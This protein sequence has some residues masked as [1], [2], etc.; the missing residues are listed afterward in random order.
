MPVMDGYQA[1]A[2]IRALEKEG[3]RHLPIVAMTANAM[4]GDRQRCLDAGMDDY[5]AKPYTMSRLAQVLERWLAHTPPRTDVEPE[6]VQE[7]APERSA[8]AIDLRH[9]E[10]LRELDPS[11]GL[12]LAHKIMRVYLET[13]DSQMEHLVEAIASGDAQGVRHAAHTL[14]SS[15]AN[16]GALSLSQLFKQME[17]SGAKADMVAAGND[18]EMA[19]R[20]YGRVVGALHELLKDEP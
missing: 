8:E 10:R 17:M 18:L 9:L 6:A 11:G 5:L 12:T 4:E 3:A 16:V 2:A 20:E 1:T 15:S 7:R 14:K 13:S 19:R